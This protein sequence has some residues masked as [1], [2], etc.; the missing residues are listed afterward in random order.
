MVGRFYMYNNHR[1][2]GSGGFR[3]KKFGGGGF[4]GGFKK[5]GFG[6]RGGFGGGS[7]GGFGGGSRGGFDKPMHDATCASCGNGCQVPFKPN[8][9]KPV[10]CNNC[11]RKDGDSAAP[12]RF[13]RSESSF[14][15][16]SES[17]GGRS[18]SFGGGRFEEKRMHQAECA[19]CGNSCEVPFK[20]NG[21]K[22]V[23]CNNCFRK[24][25]DSEMSSRPARSQGSSEA[26]TAQYK[27]IMEK[28]DAI[29][30]LLDGGKK[31]AKAKKEKKSEKTEVEADE[32]EE[33]VVVAADPEVAFE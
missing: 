15:G 23:Y 30:A 12:R 8:G 20:P 29:M 9:S 14:G 16:R 22:P 11:F 2:G 26:S 5:S 28:L 13:E 4:G 10:L 18:D 21:S 27:Q 7:R 32:K 1:D 25:G 31:P 33:E 24:D 19:T 17:F 6:D 3:G